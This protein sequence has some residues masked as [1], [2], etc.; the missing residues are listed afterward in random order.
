ML[1]FASSKHWHEVNC[2]TSSVYKS[3]CFNSITDF[4]CHAIT[5]LYHPYFGSDSQ[6]PH[7]IAPSNR[8]TLERCIFD[9]VKNTLSFL[10][11]ATVWICR[12]FFYPIP[13]HR[14]IVVPWGGQKQKNWKFWSLITL[15]CYF[16]VMKLCTVIE[17]GNKYPKLKS[18]FL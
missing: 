18:K 9:I 8:F 3:S 4:V 2:L 10:D 7:N 13:T 1:F 6:N 5:L 17:L 15:S 16:M 14:E 11:N 12:H